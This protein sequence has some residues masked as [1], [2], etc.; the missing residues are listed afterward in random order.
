M[1]FRREARASGTVRTRTAECHRMYIVR[2]KREATG[3]ED[4]PIL[5]A[6]RINIG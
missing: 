5:S 4:R 6:Y 3:V 1:S 2:G